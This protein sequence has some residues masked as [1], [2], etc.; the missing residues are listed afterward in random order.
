MGW[1]K[2]VLAVFLSLTLL[3]VSMV[4]SQR[5]PPCPSA[6]NTTG[7]YSACISLFKAL[8]SSSCCSPLKG[9]SPCQAVSCIAN[10]L[11]TFVPHKSETGQVLSRLAQVTGNACGL[12]N[13]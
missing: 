8:E 1:M 6:I 5:P 12:T 3:S 2:Y 4:R 13:A 9:L 10:V 7:L 11:P